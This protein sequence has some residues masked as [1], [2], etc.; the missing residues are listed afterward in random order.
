[1][2]TTEE[3]I[4]T[5]EMSN[6]CQC[7]WRDEYGDEILDENGDTTPMDCYGDCWN[8]NLYDFEHNVVKHLLDKS[9][10]FR[11]EGIRLWSGE[12]GGVFE[13]HNAKDFLN[14]ITVNSEWTMRYTAFADR[15]EFSLSHHDAPTGS[16]SIVYPI[17]VSD[18]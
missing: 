13:A 18:D 7:V 15:L 1:M 12:V 2:T 17:E 3:V 10:T 4:A 6:T 16:R 11:V 5:G 8:D 9:D 14:G